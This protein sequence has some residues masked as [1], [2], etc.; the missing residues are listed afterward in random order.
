ME[1]A[2]RARP[3]VETKRVRTK[4]SPEIANRSTAGNDSRSLDRTAW[5]AA[6]GDSGNVSSGHRC[7]RSSR[8]DGE[9]GSWEEAV[10]TRWNLLHSVQSANV[11]G[12]RSTIPSFKIILYICVACSVR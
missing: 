6:E 3:G 9:E 2:L 5:A 1:S 11:P 7:R 8:G 10:S 4:V 12:S